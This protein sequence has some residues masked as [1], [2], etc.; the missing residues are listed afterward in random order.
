MNN[1]KLNNKIDTTVNYNKHN[2]YEDI[3]FAKTNFNKL[4]ADNYDHYDKK[5]RHKIQNTK[6]PHT[7]LFKKEYYDKYAYAI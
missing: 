3:D 4:S 7:K 5:A 1:T 2:Y 6:K